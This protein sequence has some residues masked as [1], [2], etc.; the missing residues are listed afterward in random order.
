MGR[1]SSAACLDCKQV[2]DFG[3]G[4]YTTWL[5]SG[6][7]VAE[8]EANAAKHPELAGY[9][10]NQAWRAFLVA[11]EGHRFIQFFE[12]WA[13]VREID[14]RTVLV[15]DIEEPE[16]EIADLTGFEWISEEQVNAAIA[17][18]AALPPK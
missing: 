15:N 14:G 16:K 9:T 18:A 2:F 7:T 4:S 5:D 11:H 17:A 6:E 3:Y 13:T 1:G 8:Y 12:D 10:K